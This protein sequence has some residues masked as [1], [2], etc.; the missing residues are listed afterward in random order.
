VEVVGVFGD[1]KNATLG[2]DAA[3]E[4]ML[5]FPQ[6]PWPL[7]NL[8]IRTAGDP[9][10]LIPAIRRQVALVDKDQPLTNV[11]TMEEVVGSA[12]AQPRLTMLLLAVFSAT[13]LI[14]AIVGI[15]GVIAYSVAQRTGE[16]GIRMALGAD[17]G[18]VLKLVVGHG[19]RLTVTGIAIGMAGALVSTR[20]MSSLLYQTSATDPIAFVVSVLLFTVVAVLASYLPARRA[21]RIDPTDALR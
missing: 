5:P 18:D 19:L 20:L 6:L 11:Q 12:S 8:S 16:L 13:A 15:Y 1:R 9:H 17:Q 3:P 14:L 4:V 21:T 2:D 7:L 10:N